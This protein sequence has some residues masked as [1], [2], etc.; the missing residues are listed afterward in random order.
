MNLGELLAASARQHPDRVA[1]VW[2][3]GRRRR[4]YRELNERTD[5]LASALVDELGVRPGDRVSVMMANRP[6]VLEIQNAVWRVGATISPLNPRYTAEEIQFIVNDSGAEVF[7]AGADVAGTV[8]PLA[9]QL[10]TKSWVVVGDAP[11]QTEGYQYEELLAKHTGAQV[12]PPQT[13]DD[14][15]AWLAYTSGTTGRPKGAMLTHGCLTFVGISWLADLQRL[16]PED[17]GLVAAPLTH[18]A[19]IM[20]L[21]FVMKGSTQV[22][23]AAFDA[24]SFLEQVAVEKVTHTWLVPTQIKMILN[25]PKLDGADTSSLKTIVY[26]ASPMYVEDLREAMARIGPVFVQLFAQ[27]E[28]PMTGTYLRAEDHI[29]DG[30]G[31]ERLASCGVARSGIEV[32]VLDDQDQ[33]LPPGEVGEICI[34]GPALMKGYWNLPEATAET[35]RNGWLHTG[36]IGKMDEGGYF[37]ILDRTKDMLISGG[38]NVYPREIEEVLLRHPA[39]SEAAVVGVPSEQ[40][41]ETPHAF[42]V[43]AAG[44]TITAE[45]VIAFAADNL[46]GFKKPRSVEFLTELPKTPIGKIDKKVLRAPFWAGRQRLV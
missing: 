27:T 14:D 31:S 38:L 25:S 40:W 10:P 22:I 23:M 19:G 2:D 6:E 11:D 5:A 41:G 3:D 7:F 12:P 34:K 46:A 20:S 15:V 45:E 29:L 36:D 13:T 1:V 39:I 32:A 17:V 9:G 35:M 28:S 8:L 16:E 4:T 21:A 42:I 26:G 30:P 24:A 18:G 33:I 37:Y 43:T 44:Q